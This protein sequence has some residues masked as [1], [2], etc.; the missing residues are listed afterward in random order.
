MESTELRRKLG[1]ESTEESEM[2]R[3][4]ELMAKSLAEA[5][6]KTRKPVDEWELVEKPFSVEVEEKRPEIEKL[7]LKP[8]KSTEIGKGLRGMETNTLLDV[9]FLNPEGKPLNGIPEGIQLIITGLPGSG[10]SILVEEVAL[11]VSSNGKKVLFISSE[12][13]WKTTTSRFDL[14]ARM[15]NKCE[16]LGL[17][18]DNVSENLFVMDAATYPEFREWTKLVETYKYVVSREKIDLTVIDSLTLLEAYRGALKYRLAELMRF[19]QNHGVTALYVNQR[20]EERWDSYDIAGGIGLAH[21]ADGTVI[22]DYGRVYY[23]DQM[24]ELKAKRGDFVRIVRVLDCR[25]CGFKRERI[26]VTI[27]DN[28]FLRIAENA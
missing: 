18:W 24:Q 14:Q 27:T 13:Q 21:I 26:R 25:L 4:I 19:N 5:I 1:K 28:G 9:L 23:T 22:V 16:L 2:K 20:S 17:N 11:N 8:D 10:K 6:E 12:D 3:V 7:V 15:K